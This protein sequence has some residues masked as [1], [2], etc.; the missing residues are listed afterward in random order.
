MLF[1][2]FPTK[3]TSENNLSYNVSDNYMSL[4]KCDCS[5]SEDI[6]IASVCVFVYVR[7]RYECSVME[8]VFT[9]RQDACALVKAICQK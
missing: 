7:T 9:K 5:I 2:I 8:K 1:T 3:E 6:S 4:G